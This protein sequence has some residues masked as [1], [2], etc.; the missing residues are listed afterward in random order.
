MPCLAAA[1]ITSIRLC[2]RTNS[3]RATRQG[4][5][6]VLTAA[7]NTLRQTRAFQQPPVQTKIACTSILAVTSRSSLRQL[8]PP[9]LM[10]AC[11]QP[12]VSQPASV[13]RAE[14]PLRPLAAPGSHCAPCTAAGPYNTV[15]FVN[16][17]AAATPHRCSVYAPLQRWNIGS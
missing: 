1:C 17:S 14:R 12:R 4:M 9:S 2:P 7:M 6:P 16:A 10:Q 11:Q 13:C 5:L 3:A 15:D 8:S